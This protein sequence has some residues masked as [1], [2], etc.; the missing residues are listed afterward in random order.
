MKSLG[1]AL[2]D[3]KRQY[4]SLCQFMSFVSNESAETFEIFEIIQRFNAEVVK[5]HLLHVVDALV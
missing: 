1:A 4:K 5:Q 3:M 2:R